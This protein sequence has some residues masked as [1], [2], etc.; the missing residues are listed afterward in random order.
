MAITTKVLFSLQIEYNVTTLLIVL[1]VLL[2]IFFFFLLWGR[3]KI[4]DERDKYKNEARSQKELKEQMQ[5][6]IIDLRTKL[7]SLTKTNKLLSDQNEKLKGLTTSKINPNVSKVN[8]IEKADPVQIEEE[9]PNKAIELQVT[10]RQELSSTP[11]E[12]VFY[13]GF[14]D[15]DNTFYALEATDTPSDESFYKII[16]DDIMLHDNIDPD[17]MKM[18]LNFIENHVK[19]AC[20]ILNSKES[21][22]TKI[23]MEDSGKVEK[24][25][26]DFKITK[27]LKVKYD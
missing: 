22:H 11:S 6:E 18:A 27:K 14:P 2:L 9:S 25:G 1:Y 17:K 16:G 24:D 12:P 23:V 4:K 26:D 3:F 21:F 20:V 5:K 10:P 15:S 8:L 19:R 7:E 13:L